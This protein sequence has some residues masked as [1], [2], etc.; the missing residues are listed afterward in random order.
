MLWNQSFWGFLVS[1]VCPTVASAASGKGRCGGWG[2]DTSAA[3]R[4]WRQGG[5]LCPGCLQEESN[6][7]KRS[8]TLSWLGETVLRWDQPNI[9]NALARSWNISVGMRGCGS[10]LK[11]NLRTPATTFTSA[12]LS[13]DTASRK[14]DNK[15][16]KASSF[17]YLTLV[18]M[19]VLD[20][21]QL[22][23]HQVGIYGFSEVQYL[24]ILMRYLNW[25]KG[26]VFMYTFRLPGGWTLWMICANSAQLMTGIF[27]QRDVGRLTAVERRPEHTD[28]TGGSWNPVDPHLVHASAFHLFHAAAH[29]MGHQHSLMSDGEHHPIPL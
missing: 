19:R 4:A 24:W 6:G 11:Y 28:V 13:L 8:F 14:S 1:D 10:S 27:Q 18:V 2:R 9:P 23:S 29:H 12:V 20:A 16:Q 15:E 17:L 5:S 22:W 25:C 21:K 7:V 26:C 3:P